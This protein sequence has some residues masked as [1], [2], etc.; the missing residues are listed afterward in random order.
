MNKKPLNILILEDNND[1]AELMVAELKKNGYA[2]TWNRVETK[3][4][5]KKSL[6]DPPDLILADY[7]LPSINA[8]D[9]LKIKQEIAS[10]IPFIIVSGTIGEEFAV[11]CIKAGATDYV[12]KDRLFRLCPVVERA[13]KEAKEDKNHKQAEDLFKQLFLSS[14]NAIFIIQDGKFKLVNSQFVKE[15]GFSEEGL[16]NRDSLELVHPEDKG[17][18]REIV[19]KNLKNGLSSPFEFRG[20]RKG[21]KIMWAL[22]VVTSITY[23]G[24]KAILGNFKDITEIKRV[25]KELEQ[26]Y[27][28][29]QETMQ[30]T[31]KVI[32]KVIEVKDPYTA[33][34][35]YRVCQLATHIAK[36][37]KFLPDKLEGI[38][39]AALVHDIGKIS[40]PVEILSK[41]TKLNEIEYRLIKDHS[42][43]GYDILKTIDFPWP[44]AEI[45]LQ[46][47]ERLDG[48]GYPNNLKGDKI[49][50]EARI[51][52]VADVVEAM[53]SHRP[54]RPALG[55]DKALEEISQNKGILYDPEMVDACLKIFKEKSFKF[56]L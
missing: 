36:E 10:T 21:G 44:V 56:E 55:I 46:H 8:L 39:I 16:L 15:S 40:I 31:I 42:Q 52:G 49:L 50:P 20:V 4:S 18:V 35:Q 23:Q 37:L 51:M 1:D 48:S 24:R 19:V 54:Y 32:A 45:V 2:I 34:H 14:P 43:I 17:M 47:H 33:G 9:A 25:E 12:L 3:E 11:E 29:L 13:L 5:L 7:K 30:D 28:K 41:P 38:R 26:S 53:S 6:K 27:R 22:Q